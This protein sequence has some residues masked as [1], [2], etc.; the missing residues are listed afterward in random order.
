MVTVRKRIE[1]SETKRSAGNAR[2]RHP[3]TAD[4]ADDREAGRVVA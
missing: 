4:Q 1:L 2:G 3:V